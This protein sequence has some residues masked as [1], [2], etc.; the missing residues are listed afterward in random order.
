[1]SVIMSSVHFFRYEVIK[2]IKTGAKFKTFILRTCT[3]K[4]CNN[5]RVQWDTV[6]FDG[7]YILYITIALHEISL[8]FNIKVFV[9][10]FVCVTNVEVSGKLKCLNY[11]KYSSLKDRVLFM[12]WYSSASQGISI[13]CKQYSRMW[14]EAAADILCLCYKRN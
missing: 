14:L 1:M 12:S 7:V 5:V 11:E 6:W 8:Q 3:R 2:S 4:F 10:F 13:F 9:V